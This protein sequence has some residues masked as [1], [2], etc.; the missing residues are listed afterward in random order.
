[1]LDPSQRYNHGF[2]HAHTRILKNIMKLGLRCPLRDF[3]FYVFLLFSH[4]NSSIPARFPIFLFLFYYFLS[5]QTEHCSGLNSPSPFQIDT[6]NIF[7]FFF[8]VRFRC[9][10]FAT[11]LHFI[12]ITRSFMVW[13]SEVSDAERLEVL[14]GLSFLLFSRGLTFLL[15]SYT[16]SDSQ[17]CNIMN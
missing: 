3:E 7:F 17:G 1:M 12:I 10:F 8:V 11:S 6:F 16:F 5:D 2:I 13:I 15:F 4:L 9:F 14:R